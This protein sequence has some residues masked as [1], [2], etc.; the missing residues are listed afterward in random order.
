MSHRLVTYQPRTRLAVCY[1]TE[2]TLYCERVLLSHLQGD[3]YILL[4][5]D[6]EIIEENLSTGG[7]SGIVAVRRMR[8]DGTVLGAKDSD[9]YTFD[10]SDA[11]PITDQ[12]IGDWIDEAEY[13]YGLSRV[14][15]EAHANDLPNNLLAAAIA[16]A[17]R[18]GNNFM[19]AVAIRHLRVIQQL[20]T[21][22]IFKIT[23]SSQQT[24]SLTS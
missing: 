3:V 5:P 6:R 4:T 8:A 20:L 10:I 12:D 18:G 19:A 9:C 7:D 22:P 16:R 1:K 2:P 11:G 24:T 17:E 15:P 21:T 13:L 14:E 23:W